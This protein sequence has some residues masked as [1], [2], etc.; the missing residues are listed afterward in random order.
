M[1]ALSTFDLLLEGHLW[2]CAFSAKQK[3]KDMT[4]TMHVCLCTYTLGSTEKVTYSSIFLNARFGR[5]Q[6]VICRVIDNR[7]DSISLTLQVS[8]RRIRDTCAQARYTD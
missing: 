7:S 3:I 6:E 1:T 5:P 8:I 2:R 4:E